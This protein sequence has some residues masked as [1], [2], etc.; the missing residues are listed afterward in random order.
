MQRLLVVL[1]VLLLLILLVGCVPREREHPPLVNDH[2][3][4]R[5]RKVEVEGAVCFL[6]NDAISCV[7]VC[8]GD[9]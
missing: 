1:G 9:K 6:F 4:Y 3:Y 8:N 5:V 2:K 7:E